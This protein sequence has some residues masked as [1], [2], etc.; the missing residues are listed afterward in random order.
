M[1]RLAAIDIGTV[2]TRLLVADVEGLQVVPLCQRTVI[3]HL[4]EGVAATRELSGPALLRVESAIGGFH[5]EMVRIEREGA[6]G[7]AA[8]PIERVVAVATSAARD[9]RNSHLL[10]EMLESF[11]IEL[12]VIEGERAAQLSFLGATSAFPGAGILLADVGGGST[13]LVLGDARI[14]GGHGGVDLRVHRRHSFDVGCRRVT[15]LFLQGDPPSDGEM[16]RAREAVRRETASFFEGLPCAPRLLLCVG[17]TATTLVAMHLE[18][19][20]YDPTRVD[21]AELTY[22]DLERLLGRLSALERVEREKMVGLQPER[23]GVI[24]AGTLVFLELLELACLPSLTVSESDILEGILL[25][26][27]ASM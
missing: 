1:H 3:T 27:A 2:T 18:L 25:D 7:A 21:G 20:P 5:D 24:I 11:G 10:E 19:E 12:L 9:A 15:D 4:G 14:D 6:D 8:G 16:R 26:A 13:E 22:R 17:G 23:A